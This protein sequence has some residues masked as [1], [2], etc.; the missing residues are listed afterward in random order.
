MAAME[1]PPSRIQHFRGL[2]CK[3]ASYLA[4]V[5]R[6]PTTPPAVKMHTMAA[7]NTCTFAEGP[8]TEAKHSLREGLRW[9]PQAL[10]PQSDCHSGS[11]THK[12]AATS[13]TTFHTCSIDIVHAKHSSKHKQS[14]KINAL[15]LNSQCSHTNIGSLARHSCI[16][17]GTTT[18]LKA[19]CVY[20]CVCMCLDL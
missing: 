10:H 6:P 11:N 12:Q 18:L 4:L 2:S 1:S 9:W 5:A 19:S 15:Q 20:M 8:M 3:A 13:P 16:A 7:T 14:A 17:E